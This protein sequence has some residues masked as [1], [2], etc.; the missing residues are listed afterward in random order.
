MNVSLFFILF[1]IIELFIVILLIVIEWACVQVLAAEGEHVEARAWLL[2]VSSFLQ[3]FKGSGNLGGQAFATNVFICWAI[4]VTL[5]Y[6]S[7]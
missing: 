5:I 6:F 7:I 2:G 1:I 3:H 4:Q